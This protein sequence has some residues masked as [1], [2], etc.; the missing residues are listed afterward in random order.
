MT[1]FVC[2]LFF[3]GTGVPDCA[4]NKNQGLSQI[5]NLRQPLFVVFLLT[6]QNNCD[7]ILIS[8]KKEI[9]LYGRKDFNKQKARAFG[10]GA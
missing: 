8:N 2:T 5:A 1:F 7:I 9:K 6:N 4:L 10:A 3:V